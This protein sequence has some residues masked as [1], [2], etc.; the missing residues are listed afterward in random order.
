MLDEE[1]ENTQIKPI[2][3]VIAGIALLMIIYI[4]F[5]TKTDLSIT[6]ENE[7]A[8][9]N[10]DA[11]FSTIKDNYTLK[12]V[13]TNDTGTTMWEFDREKD[14]KLYDLN[15]NTDNEKGYAVYNNKTFIFDNEHK[16]YPTNDIVTNKDGFIN[17]KLI[18][19]VLKECELEIVS[20]N[21]SKCN[22]NTSKYIEKYNEYYNTDYK[23]D[24]SKTEISIVYYSNE[25]HDINIDYTNINKIINESDS[26]LNYKMTII[27]I[28]ENDYSDIYNYY[29]EVLNK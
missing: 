7:N 6:G 13:A 11:L 17:L 16:L 19:D 18:R 25:I 21:S 1:K 20:D 15:M 24:D 3:F 22:I 29:K 14:L 10:I 23:S 28:N 12:I 27:N 5:G 8:T 26:K 2:A 9:I 4:I